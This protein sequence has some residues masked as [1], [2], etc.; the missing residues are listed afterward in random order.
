MYVILLKRPKFPN[1]FNIGVFSQ[2][3][4][5]IYIYNPLNSGFFKPIKLYKYL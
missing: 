1:P 5:I 4:Y 2:S 3:N